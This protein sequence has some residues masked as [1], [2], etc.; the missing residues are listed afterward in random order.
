MVGVESEKTD[1]QGD[2]PG[3]PSTSPAG[4][5]RGFAHSVREDISDPASPP[6]VL[7]EEAPAEQKAS[8]LTAR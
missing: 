4:R 1:G 8:T 5:G 3:F 2:S 7:A 6:S